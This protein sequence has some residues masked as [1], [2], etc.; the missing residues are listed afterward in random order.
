[1]VLAAASILIQA[2]FLPPRIRITTSIPRTAFCICSKGD[3]E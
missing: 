3:V 1:M 2:L